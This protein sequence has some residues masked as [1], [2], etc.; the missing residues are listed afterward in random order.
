MMKLLYK[1]LLDKSGNGILAVIG[2]DGRHDIDD[3]GGSSGGG[4]TNDNDCWNIILIMEH[5]HTE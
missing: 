3:D 4:G 1:F 5:T 2:I